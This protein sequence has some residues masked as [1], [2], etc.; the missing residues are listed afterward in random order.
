M[1]DKSYRSQLQIAMVYFLVA[2]ILG[3]LLRFYPILGFNFNYKFVVHG[4]SH[5]ALLGWVYVALTTLLHFCFLE[6]KKSNRTY[7]RIFWCTQ[8]TLVGMLFSFPFQGYALF[9]IVFST[10]F[11]IV[12]YVYVHHFWKNIDPKYNH[13]KGLKCVKAAL[14]YM[15]ISSLGPWALGAIM[16]SIGPNS[17]WYR[18]AIYFYLHFQYNGWMILALLGLFLFV[19]EQY[20]LKISKKTFVRLFLSLNVGITFTFFLSTLWTNPSIWYY[21]LAGI[22]AIAQLYAFACLWRI[23]KHRLSELSM[24]KMQSSLLM[25]VIILVSIKIVLQLLTVLPYFSNMAATI[26]DL[27][28]GYLHLT[29][30]GVISI[31]L[32]FLMDYLKLFRISQKSY[33]WYMLGFILTEILIFYKGL[34]AWQHWSLIKG[35]TIALAV[36]SLLI[37]VGLSFMLV[38]NWRKSWPL[39]N[40]S[41]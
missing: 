25:S 26:L 11:L 4:H 20:G 16:N 15:V 28:I 41:A 31:G 17:I 34:A 39:H 9:S 30:L 10:L 12:S 19:W 14:I 5:I 23:I 33:L 24:S 38:Q 21:T 13:S 29:F 40:D 3:L 6:K 2:A 7:K 1:K 22:G 36:F 35:Q 32:F 27:T 18:L 37:I 8:A